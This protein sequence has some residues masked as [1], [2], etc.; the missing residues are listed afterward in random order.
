MKEKDQKRL[1]NELFYGIDGEED[2]ISYLDMLLR[3]EGEFE[4]LFEVVGNEG[5]KKL[6]EIFCRRPEKFYLGLQIEKVSLERVYLKNSEVVNGR[7][8]FDQATKTIPNLKKA[9]SFMEKYVDMESGVVK[10]SGLEVEDVVKKI[11]RDFFDYENSSL[12]KEDDD[13]KKVSNYFI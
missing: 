10:E 2:S 5:R 1:M 13:S 3:G 9:L 8:L 11:L 12:S 6:R 4:D 7:N